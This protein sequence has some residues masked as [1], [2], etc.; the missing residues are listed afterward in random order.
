M[1]SAG[2][3]EGRLCG[4]SEGTLSVLGGGTRRQM[5]RKANRKAGP[6]ACRGPPLAGPGIPKAPGACYFW[7]EPCGE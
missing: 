5:A 2:P 3:L 7:T 4:D 6:Q 1:L